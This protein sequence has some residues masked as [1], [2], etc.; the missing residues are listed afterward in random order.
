MNKK[1]TYKYV[2]FFLINSSTD[3][4]CIQE[5]LN[6]VVKNIQIKWFV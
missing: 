6:K 4:E 2:L 1:D 3:F 5:L